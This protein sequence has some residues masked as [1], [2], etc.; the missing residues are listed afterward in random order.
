MPIK[1][2]VAITYNIKITDS[3]WSN[4]SGR[5]IAPKKLDNPTNKLTKD[6][7]QSNKI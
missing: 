5:I 2:V 1:P 4:R 7:A 6:I 3:P